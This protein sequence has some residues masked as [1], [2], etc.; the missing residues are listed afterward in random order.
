MALVY[1][2]LKTGRLLAMGGQVN[3]N[4]II[5]AVSQTQQG[6]L[7]A[8]PVVVYDYDVAD[9]DWIPHLLDKKIVAFTSASASGITSAIFADPL[10]G[11]WYRVGN[12]N[13][14]T[15]LDN[16]ITLNDGVSDIITMIPG[17]IVRIYWNTTVGWIKI[18]GN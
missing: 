7:S 8:P 1:S 14:G 12:V 11:D 5:K 4:D 16:T 3:L 15:D 17:E 6:Y 18:P 9:T 2:G 13:P 10:E